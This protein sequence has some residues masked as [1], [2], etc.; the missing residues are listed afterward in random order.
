[1]RQEKEE[2]KS[3][4][5]KKSIEP[6]KIGEQKFKEALVIEQK[7]EESER[8]REKK[9]ARGREKRVNVDFQSILYGR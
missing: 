1:M 2:K 9:T 5:H 6:K 7:E 8:E 3:W 4:A